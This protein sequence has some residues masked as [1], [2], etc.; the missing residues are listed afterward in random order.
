MLKRL[1]VMM[2]GLIAI[3]MGWLYTTHECHATVQR[4]VCYEITP[5]VFKCVDKTTG[6]QRTIIKL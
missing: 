5:G 1:S 6:N 4:E 2:L 3:F